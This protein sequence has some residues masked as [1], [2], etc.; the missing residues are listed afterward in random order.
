M[1]FQDT[2]AS[3]GVAALHNALCALGH[4]RSLAELTALIKP[5]TVGTP[6]ASM[7]RAVQTLKE[8]CGLVPV[9]YQLGNS[10]A[11]M[12]MMW[13]ALANGRPSVIIVDRGEHWVAVVGHLR[14]RLHVADGARAELILSYDLASFGERW[15]CGGR[16]AFTA[17]G[18]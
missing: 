10:V 6:V 7:W 2:Q 17:I 18:L 1:L 13:A 4:E 5:G 12:G 16:H 14:N 15:N 11:A 9:K 3:C 8:S